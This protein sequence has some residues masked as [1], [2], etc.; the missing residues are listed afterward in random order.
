[1]E[2]TA[3]DT[4]VHE[5]EAPLPPLVV[6]LDG[7]LIHSDLLWEAMLLFLRTHP[8]QA[9]RLPLWLLLGKAGFKQKLAAAVCPDATTL[10]YDRALVEFIQ[11]ERRQGRTIVLATGSERR[12]AQAVADHLQLFDEVHA[13]DEGRNLT[14]HEKAS[15]LRSLYGEKGYDYIGNAAC[16]RAVWL[17]SRN[18]FSVTRKPFL[19]ADGRSTG[20]LGTMRGGRGRALLKA[21]R[22]RQWLKNLL[23]FVP[24]LAGHQLDLD[25]ALLSLLA[26]AA[27]SLCASSAYLLNDALDASDD[28][29]HP[30]KRHRPLAAGTL[31]L[32]VAML[33]SPLMALA[34]IG[35]AAASGPQLL[36]ALAVYFVSTLL[37]SFHLKRLLMVDVVTLALLYSMRIIGGA[38]ATGIALSSWLLGFSFFVFLSLAMLKRYSELFNLNRQGKQTARGRGYTTAD[39]VPVGVMGVCSA[40]MSVLVFMLYFGS[41]DVLVLYARPA[42]LAGVVPLLVLWLGRLWILAAR[43]QIHEDPVLYVSRDRVSLAVFA[44]CGAL[45]TIATF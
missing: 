26:F 22:P 39:K 25:T 23:V 27:F 15:H 5:A 13:T 31:P 29:V 2:N 21:V 41:P 17:G 1:M 9:W 16:D 37:Y 28:R 44:L 7:T 10:P 3:L 34:A 20:Q 35:I 4:P 43:G 30:E 19:L 38:A 40:F 11:Q 32:P 18:A 24:M 45:A 33:A 14:S 12:F 6:D 42:W 36:L 8:L